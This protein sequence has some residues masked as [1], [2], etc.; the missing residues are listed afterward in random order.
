M[1]HKLP[2]PFNRADSTD[3]RDVQKAILEIVKTVYSRH[4]HL[5]V[6]GGGKRL[7]SGAKG[8]SSMKGAPDLLMC[9]DSRIWGI[10][11]KV[12]GGTVSE[13]QIKHLNLIESSGGRGVIVCSVDGFLRAMNQEQ[14]TAILEGIGVF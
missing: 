2:A 10:E 5:R 13:E 11:I 14:P 7:G 4:W 8:K 3:E 1:K 9:I 12:P 6:E